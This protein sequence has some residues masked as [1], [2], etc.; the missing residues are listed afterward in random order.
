MSARERKLERERVT[1]RE[2]QRELQRIFEGIEKEDRY[3]W[4]I[5]FLIPSFFF[6]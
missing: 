3:F 5:D 6:L 4:L 2:L 1:E